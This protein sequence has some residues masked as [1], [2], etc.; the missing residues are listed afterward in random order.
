MQIRPD[1]NYGTKDPH[2][3]RWGI[4]VFVGDSRRCALTELGGGL[5]RLPN[6]DLSLVQGRDLLVFGNIW[7]HKDPNEQT[8]F[9]HPDQLNQLGVTWWYWDNPELP[10][11][12]YR[13]AWNTQ[14]HKNWLRLV[15]CNTAT[16]QSHLDQPITD[17]I[18]QC[19]HEHI[20]RILH[21]STG[22][23]ISSWQ[24]CVGEIR[25]CVP[26][27]RRILIAP[28]GAGVF[29]HYYG[30]DRHTWIAQ[31]AE[32]IRQLG[33]EPVMRPKPSRR[34]R[35]HAAAGRLCDLLKREDFAA[36]LCH[37]SVIPVE[38]QLA[39]VP[40]I[41]AGS[42]TEMPASITWDQFCLGVPI[43]QVDRQL[44]TEQVNRI[45]MHTHHKWSAIHG[46]W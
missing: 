24:H 35:E 15:P 34:Q 18:S 26:R 9:R 22:G 11:L 45:L 43:P 38:A 3:L 46:G 14:G 36:V 41:T 37:H 5:E 33:Y 28:S 42:C 31:C 8:L 21:N 23:E 2:G 39:G 30:R 19:S 4:S 40:T 17:T 27:G 13:G 6:Q 7:V 1:R 29:Q 25:D 20:D 12:L 44:V 10:H 16:Q 32:R